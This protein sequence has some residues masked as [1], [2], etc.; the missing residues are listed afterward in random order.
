MTNNL[1]SMNF[2]TVGASAYIK[3]GTSIISGGRLWGLYEGYKLTGYADK[4]KYATDAKA[5]TACTSSSTCK[6]VTKE[7][8][9]NY[10]INTGNTPSVKKSME[11]Y[12]MGSSVTTSNGYYW[13]SKS[14]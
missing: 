2:Q 13:A 11:C 3:S 12:I 8:S 7:G 5:F 10:R 4:V 9:A 6:G 1:I 14:S